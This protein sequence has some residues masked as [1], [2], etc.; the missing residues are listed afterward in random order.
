MRG[1]QSTGKSQ[2]EAGLGRMYMETWERYQVQP[3]YDTLVCWKFSPGSCGVS[4]A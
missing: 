4:Q 1:S 2:R 3:L